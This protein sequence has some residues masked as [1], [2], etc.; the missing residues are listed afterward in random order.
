M[1]TEG[2]ESFNFVIRLRSILSN[3]HAPSVDIAQAMSFMHAVRHLVSGG[4]IR[5]E[6]GTM[7]QAGVQ[8]RALAQDRAFVKL[9]G[10]EYLDAEVH[11]GACIAGSS[12]KISV[13]DD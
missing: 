9:M 1:A 6:R 2:F 7:R 4:W 10:M 5:D 12:D 11:A 8:V 13:C 3:R